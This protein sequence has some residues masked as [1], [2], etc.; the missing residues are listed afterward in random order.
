MRSRYR[1][2]P[3]YRADLLARFNV[4]AAWLGETCLARSGA[5]FTQDAMIRGLGDSAASVPAES[6]L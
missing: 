6:R 4:M 1:E 5:S 3:D 2:R